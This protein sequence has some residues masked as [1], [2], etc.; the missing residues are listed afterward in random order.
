M[1][2]I[3]LLLLFVLAS[4]T[5]SARGSWLNSHSALNLAFVGGNSNINSNSNSNNNTPRGDKYVSSD[6]ALRATEVTPTTT[7]TG[8][9]LGPSDTDADAA[10]IFDSGCVA[11]PV[12]LPPSKNNKSNDK[13]QMYYY[14]NPGTWANETRCFLPTGYVGLAESDDGIHWEK[15]PGKEEFGSILAPTCVEDDF[16]GL[17]L[18]VGDVIRVNANA[19]NGDESEEL[20][21]Y[22]FGASFEAVSLGKDAPMPPAQGLRMRIGKAVSTD[23]GRSWE[24]RGQVLDYDSKEG[25]FASWPR[26]IVPEERDVDT[27][28]RMLYH[29]FNGTQWAV[30]EAISN[31]KG[32]TWARAGNT[33]MVLGPGD[34]DGWDGSGV[35]TRAVARTTD[36]ALVMV[37][38][39]VGGGAF[40]GTHRLGVARWND[41]DE[42]ADGGGAWIKDTAITGVPG[43]PI[44]EPGVEPLQPWTAQVIGTPYMVANPAKDGSMR[45]YFCAKKDSDM[46]MSIGLVESESGNFD[47]S[48]WKAISPKCTDDED[49]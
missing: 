41:N 33:K 30:F 36:G 48:S 18:G 49:Q 31:D 23:N 21:M 45:L 38:E 9:V 34:S 37:Y 2:T 5:V 19:D 40:T 16:D 10:T 46:N 7:T 20:H 17:Q 12:V 8:P 1:T 39:A 6:S 29:T 11:C 22:Y 42:N 25:L 47:P 27:P 3:V 26:L 4:T 32:E 14:G 24:R 15:I 28:W 43:G 13:W 35:G 44:L